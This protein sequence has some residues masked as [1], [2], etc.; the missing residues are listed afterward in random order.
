MCSLVM[1]LCSHDAITIHGMGGWQLI[2]RF[3]LQQSAWFW[4]VEYQLGNS[5][6][7]ML[8]RG[9]MLWFYCVVDGVPTMRVYTCIIKYDST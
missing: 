3:N 5:F 6:Q 8:Y 7:V 9:L 2:N 4:M 1:S